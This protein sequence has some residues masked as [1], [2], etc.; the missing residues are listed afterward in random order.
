MRMR[1]LFPIPTNDPKQDRPTEIA[2]STRNAALNLLASRDP[3]FS[4][5]SDAK[6]W[7]ERCMNVPLP[8]ISGDDVSA[9]AA[10][11]NTNTNTNTSTIALPALHT[12][13][14]LAPYLDV[15]GQKLVC[16]KI[17]LQVTRATNTLSCSLAILDKP[18]MA[19]GA[20]EDYCLWLAKRLDTKEDLVQ[21]VSKKLFLQVWSIFPALSKVLTDSNAPR[22]LTMTAV[23]LL[24][25]QANRHH[26]VI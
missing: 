4:L 11:S 13:V 24:H 22:L 17:F 16:D 3:N 8:T 19:V 7:S 9:G 5:D 23:D 2:S 21:D 25:D 26:L 15:T 18:P 12:L 14:N 10:G 1:V 6:S 20:L